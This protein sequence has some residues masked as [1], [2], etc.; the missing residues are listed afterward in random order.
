MMGV[1]ADVEL[2]GG[3]LN[4]FWIG[5]GHQLKIPVVCRRGVAKVPLPRHLK[6]PKN[7]LGTLSAWYY[8]YLALCKWFLSPSIPARFS[9]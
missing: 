9:D 1:K 6:G 2:T 5:I 3:F 8:M 7:R 4:L